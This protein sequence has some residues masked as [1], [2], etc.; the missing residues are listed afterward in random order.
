MKKKLI[1]IS[2]LFMFAISGTIQAADYHEEQQIDQELGIL[3]RAWNFVYT[4]L[5]GREQ[6]P[7]QVKPG[8][9][10]YDQEIERAQDTRGAILPSGGG[11]KS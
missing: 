8:A 5:F 2:V 4:R 10:T 7:A 6:L 1:I 3:D 9:P 11:G